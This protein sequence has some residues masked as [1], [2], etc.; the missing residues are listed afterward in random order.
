MKHLDFLSPGQK[1]K[2]LRNQLGIKQI[3]LEAIGVSRNYISMIE[4][5]KRHLNANTLEKLITFFENR[6]LELDRDFNID[7]AKLAL[8]KKD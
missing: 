6:A 3:E 8:S 2:Q 5:D 1:L 7:K 4:S